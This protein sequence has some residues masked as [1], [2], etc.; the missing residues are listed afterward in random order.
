MEMIP[1]LR[2]LTIPALLGLI[3]IY[4]SNLEATT[5]IWGVGPKIVV[6]EDGRDVIVNGPPPRATPKPSTP[7]PPVPA[8]P[9]PTTPKPGS[10]PRP[11]AAN[12]AARQAISATY[13]QWAE[14]N[15]TAAM[16]SAVTQPDH[17]YAM[18]VAQVWRGKDQAA[19]EAWYL[20]IQNVALRK[21]IS[22]A[23]PAKHQINIE[24]Q[25]QHP[26][27]PE[28]AQTWAVFE[29]ENDPTNVERFAQTVS[30]PLR[31][32]LIEIAQTRP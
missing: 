8:T 30:E 19:F 21:S 25:R 24:S 17:T 10:T 18:R 3:I 9:K 22:L 27:F 31:G 26:D 4:Q 13:A 28:I 14:Q 32:L 15:P 5:Y 2:I 16:Q 20:Q 7:R 1:I 23:I 29:A 11:T 12:L 6:I